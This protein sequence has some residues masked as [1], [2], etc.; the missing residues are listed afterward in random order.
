[1]PTD[2]YQY[3]LVADLYDFVHPYR[4]RPDIDFFVEAATNA[5][6]PVLE[7]GCGTGRVLIPTARAGIAITGLDAS[8]HMLA[9]CRQRL[10]DEPE[11]VRSH[12]TV[13]Q[14]DMRNFDIDE[15]FNLVTIP[16]RPL[17]HLLT[18]DDQLSCLECI[19]GHLAAGGHLVFDV[20]NPSLEALVNG[21]FEEESDAEPEFTMPD[22]RR[23]VRRHRTARPDRFLQ[24]GQY[25]LIYEVTH[26]DGREERMMHAFPLRYFFKFEI[27]H[28]LARVGF[29]VEHVYAEFDKSPYG[30][31]YPGELIVVATR[32]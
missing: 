32:L 31:S 3:A 2:L 28:L 11:T 8:P 17:Q 27:E 29:A 9:I 30:S 5:G 4:N 23:V 19:R 26:P 12:V 7:L 22:G 21:P 25:E 1:M 6:G 18:T 13:V 10:S 20:F 24:V 14:G 15:T 16:F